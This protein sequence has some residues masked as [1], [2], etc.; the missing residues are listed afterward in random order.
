M[1]IQVAR[2]FHWTISIR[3]DNVFDRGKSDC[4]LTFRCLHVSGS[5]SFLAIFFSI[6]NWESR[7]D[8]LVRTSRE[9]FRLLP[10]LEDLFH[11]G[12]P[13]PFSYL[14]VIYTYMQTFGFPR[15]FLS[16]ALFQL[17]EFNAFSLYGHSTGVP[18]SGRHFGFSVTEKY[19]LSSALRSPR[20]PSGHSKLFSYRDEKK[21]IKLAKGNSSE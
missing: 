2:S 5:L 11:P 6:F 15:V 20:V 14:L 19:T 7:V 16:S 13:N 1:V 17:E 8:Q 4:F 3:F 12:N 9:K 18:V 10:D 21:S